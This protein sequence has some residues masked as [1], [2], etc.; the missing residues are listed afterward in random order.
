LV[1]VNETLV[2]REV[3]DMRRRFGT[4]SDA[5]VAGDKDMLL[6]D[7]IELAGDGTIKPGGLM[8]RTTI[9]L[10]YI[11]DDATRQL[12]EGRAAGDEVTVLA[13]AV[14]ENQEDLARMLNTDVA[15]VQGLAG[16]LLFRIA[17][18]K[19]LEPVELGQELFD[20]VYGK[21]AVTDEAGFRAKV[22][23]GL[24]GMFRRDSDRIFKRV[25]MKKVQEK[26]AIALPDGFL[27]RWI[28]MN[29]DRHM[30]A[31]EL[32]AGY[33]GYAEGLR[34]Q[35]VEEKVIEKYGLEA[36]GEEMDAFAKRYITDQFGQYGMPAPEGEDLQRMVGRILG[37]RDQL[38]RMRDTI[39]EQKLTNH[40]KALLSPKETK[41]TFDEFVNLARTA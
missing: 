10:E 19:R 36:K 37:D 1:D 31:G 12:F 17:E 21:D 18:V 16:S 11:K 33:P 39:V 38:K 23:E 29:S 4:M 32:E 24:E 7:L 34:R 3:T 20:R 8:N 22:K 6:G 41:V 2:E 9:S 28:V 27:K 26:A 13:S 25:A 35:L 5:D 30:T 15:G 14:A 40:F